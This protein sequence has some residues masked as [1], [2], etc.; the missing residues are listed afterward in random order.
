MM[1]LYELR[2]GTVVSAA[3]EKS[4]GGE[5]PGFLDPEFFKQANM[6]CSFLPIEVG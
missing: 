5:K 2:Y 6:S 3:E 4:K 1:E